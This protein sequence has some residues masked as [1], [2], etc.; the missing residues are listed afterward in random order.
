[1]T[2]AEP[3]TFNINLPIH[4]R[5]ARKDDVHLLEWYGQYKH[6]RNLLRR[7]YREQMQGKRLMLVADCND[8]PIGQIFIQLKSNNRQIANGFNRAY[9][10]S[11]RVM[12]IF[13]GNGIGTRLI[14]SAESTI[15]QRGYNWATIAVAKENIHAIRLYERLGYQKFGEDPGQWHY[16][17]HR[18]EVRNVN[19]PCWI[20]EKKLVMV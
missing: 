2:T 9:F 12:E 4:I 8:F 13:R 11:F 20:L 3:T 6:F 18:G 7:A 17:D 19:E 16:T 1:M 10:Y 15:Q 14:E 5:I